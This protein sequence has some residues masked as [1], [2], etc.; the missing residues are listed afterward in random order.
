MPKSLHAPLLAGGLATLL[1]AVAAQEVRRLPGPTGD[2]GPL[3]GLDRRWGYKAIKAVGNHGEIFE[4]NPGMSGPVRLPRGLNDLWTRG[5]LM[6]APP[7]R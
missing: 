7:V 5:G 1:G 6:Y 4:R 2:H 3:M